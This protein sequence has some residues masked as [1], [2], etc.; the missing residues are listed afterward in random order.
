[1]GVAATG[2]VGMSWGRCPGVVG[3][4]AGG[5]CCKLTQFWVRGV[6]GRRMG[7]VGVDWDSGRGDTILQLGG[8]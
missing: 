6:A 7:G 2:P 1:M 5:S 4:E 8:S 3:G